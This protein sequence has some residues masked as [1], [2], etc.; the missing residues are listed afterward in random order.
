MFKDNKYTNIYIAIVSNAI[1][2]RRY[3][4]FGYFERHHILPRSM[5]GDDVE[6]NLVL[7][8][9]REHFICHYLL[10]K[11]CVSGR[12]RDRMLHA[13]MLMKG[14]NSGQQRYCNSRLYEATKAAYGQS[15]REALVG[16]TKSPEHK[17]KISASLTG[18]VTSEETKRKQ[19]ENASK[20]PRKPFSE[21]YRKQMSER[22]KGRPKKPRNNGNLG[23]G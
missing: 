21:E 9:G 13:F 20:R 4:V 3:K 14:E 8:T 12:D 18:K 10:T 22:M 19:S 5:G 2:Q 17:A 1:A 16:T 6:S 15:R 23:T 11:M 7:L